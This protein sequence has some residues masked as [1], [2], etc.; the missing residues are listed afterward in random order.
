MDREEFW[1]IIDPESR[2]LELRL[3]ERQHYYN[4][5]RLMVF[6]NGVVDGV[7]SFFTGID[8]EAWDRHRLC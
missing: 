8:G 2:D 6:L 7:F 1:A 3:A 4:W 5:P